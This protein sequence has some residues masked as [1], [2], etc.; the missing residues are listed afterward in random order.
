MKRIRR[1][2]FCWRHG[3]P[4]WI[5]SYGTDRQWVRLKD[6]F[7]RAGPMAIANAATFARES[8][9]NSLLRGQA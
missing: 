2:W 1:L 5:A 6:D 8:F 4:F 3:L 9:I 7:R